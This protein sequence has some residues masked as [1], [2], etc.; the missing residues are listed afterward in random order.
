MRQY[1]ADHIYNVGI[2]SHG[3]AGRTTLVE[4]ML[5]D[6]GAINRRGRVSLGTTTSDTDPEEIKRH[7]SLTNSVIP[8]EYND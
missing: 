5:F 3:G 6:T 4:A 2:F 8:I 7:F 1:P